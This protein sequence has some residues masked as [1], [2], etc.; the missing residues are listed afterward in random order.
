MYEK[1]PFDYL[2]DLLFVAIGFGLS[3]GLLTLFSG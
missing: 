3:Y 1:K 2:V